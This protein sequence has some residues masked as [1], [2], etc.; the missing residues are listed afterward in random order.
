VLSQGI[1]YNLR[2]VSNVP[3]E[4][5]GDFINDETLATGIFMTFI[6]DWQQARA[7]L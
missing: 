7:S 1:G 4:D 6:G 3:L 5:T 2:P